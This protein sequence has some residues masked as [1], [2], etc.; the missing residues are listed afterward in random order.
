VKEVCELKRFLYTLFALA[1]VLAPIG[2]GMYY[3]Q[4]LHEFFGQQLGYELLGNAAAGLLVAITAAVTLLLGRRLINAYVPEVKAYR[5][6]TPQE[7]RERA[8]KEA[9]AAV[10]KGRLGTAMLV[11][12]EAGLLHKAMEM[13][14]KLEDVPAQ[15]RI[16]T[17]LRHYAGARWLYV[18]AKDFESAGHISLLMNEVEEAREYYAK[19]A[20]AAKDNQATAAEQA[21]LWE[22]AGDY[23]RAAELYEE[24][25]ELDRAAECY[26]LLG[27]RRNTVRCSDQGKAIEAFE[28]KQAGRTL[29]EQER[30]NEQEKIAAA[31]KAP[32]L[33]ALG[34]FFGAG[35]QYRIAGKMMEAGLAFERAD[36]WERAA[37]AYREASLDDRAELAMMHVP[38]KE[39]PEDETAQALAAPDP[40]QA[41]RTA[42]NPIS[43]AQAIPVYLAASGVTALNPEAHEEM[44]QQVRRGRFREA[45]Q[46]AAVANNWPLAAAFFEC[47]GALVQAADTYRQI[48][49]LGEASECLTRAGRPRE[50]ALMSLAE[51]RHDRAVESLLRAIEQSDA[52]EDAGLLLAELLT[53]C[54]KVDD[55]LALLRRRVAPGGPTPRNAKTFYHFARLMENRKH[56]E[57]ALEIYEEMAAAG[58]VSDDIANRIERLKQE[59]AELPEAPESSA[60]S[61]TTP[62]D[63]KQAAVI[64]ELVTRAIEAA[65]EPKAGRAMALRAAG[66][67]RT[68]QFLAPEDEAGSA[69]EG[70]TAAVDLPRANLSLFGAPEKEGLTALGDEATSLSAVAGDG[71][72]GVVTRTRTG[73]DPFGASQRYERKREI[74]RGGMGVVYEAV[75]TVLQ[76]PVALKLILSQAATQQGL[77]QFLLEA[78]AIAQLSHPNVVMIYD[79]GL[80]GLRHYIAMELVAGGSLSQLVREEKQLSLAESMRIFVEMALGLRTAHD[81]GIVHRDI[82]PSNIL[83][84]KDRQVKIVDFGLAKIAQDGGGTE[85]EKTMFRSSG[86]PGYMSPEQIRGEKLLPRCDIYALGITLFHMLV[87]KPPHKVANITNEFDIVKFQVD[88]DLPSLKM[89]RPEVPSAVDKM[90]RYCVA[91][92]PEERYQSIGAFLGTAEKWLLELT[93]KAKAKA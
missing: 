88:G 52:P 10:R 66:G 32:K 87:G 24:G 4:D 34:D 68:F 22:R 80:M 23:R 17:A 75:D 44:L 1:V 71:T 91:A 83:L 12:E 58:A 39:P 78:R 54:N 62:L 26:E 37:N 47:S 64:E 92:N 84:T 51:G 35:M 76:R 77:Q 50:A 30:L 81:A 42:F 9:A 55:V 70:A 67:E 43:Q 63:K 28:R 5:R 7:R 38:P 14:E 19:A 82:K 89:L 8:E 85:G 61:A 48:G 25:A 18:R 16:A 74:A 59:V 36:E 15:A 11:Y 21:A 33:E 40:H 93:A 72:A 41:A 20:E 90:F 31:N 27:D 60:E 56:P 57:A 86:T 73:E 6:L 45:A 79:I 69:W 2:F 46:K 13:A 29:V 65:P 3:W 49:R 53:D